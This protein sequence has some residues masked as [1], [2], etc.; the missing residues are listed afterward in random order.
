M[1]KIIP[2]C[3]TL[4]ILIGCKEEVDTS[5]RY[6]FKEESV[7][8][9][10]KKHADVYSTYT[11]ILFKV[12]VSQISATTLGQL[13][14]AR[15][16]Y[17][18][19]APTNDAIQ[20]YLDT[21][22]AS[23]IIDSPSWDG[24]RDSLTLDSIR[25]VIA[26]NSIIDGGDDMTYFTT[27][28]PILQDAEIPRANMYDRRLVVHQPNKY[29]NEDL[30]LINDAPMDERNHDIPLL[31]GCIHSMNAVICPSNNTLGHLLKS[32]VDDREEGFYV[33]SMLAMAAG[34][35]DTLTLHT[36][37]VYEDKFLRGEII[38]SIQ[39]IHVAGSVLVPAPGFCTPEHRYYGY[40]YFAE[41][42]SV[43]RELLGKDPLS[44][45]PEDIM[46]YLESQNIYPEAKR[47][48]DYKDEDNLL[49]RFV[50]YHLL[51][52]RL[53]TDKL[54][55]HYNEVGYIPGTGTLGVAMSE[56]YTTMGKRRLLKIYESHE[57]NGIFL[58]RFPN[59]N[60]GRHG[61]YHELSCDPD[62][63][64]IRIGA[65]NLTGKNN[66][67]NGMLYPIDK[68]LVYDEKTR[69]NLVRNR[70][71]WD[72]TAMMPEFI[73]NDIRMSPIM[74]VPHMNVRIPVTSEYRYLE[75]VDISDD[76]QFFYWTGLGNGWLN[77]DGDEF[78]IRGL[79]DVTFRLPPVPKR[80]TYEIR[81]AVN[82]TGKRRV[83]AQ[84]YWGKDK[85]HLA[86]QGIPLD[87]RIGPTTVNTTTLS[88]PSF[89]GWEPDTGDEDYDAEIDKQLRNKGF[90]KG[91]SIHYAGGPGSGK[92]AR[93]S[94][95]NSRRI[96]V[97]QTMDPDETYY[98]RFKT[99]I[100]DIT[101]YLYM[102]YLEY[103]AKEVYDNPETP[104]DIW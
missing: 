62:K 26:Y 100:D 5:A 95:L 104:E 41:T 13:L 84:F 42:D 75:D 90:M 51:P 11:D 43:W 56:F 34:L 33:A 79:Q 53:P 45:T 15:G 2:L 3:M 81:Y 9:Y 7:T 29:E 93:E 10:L 83:I 37:Y 8:S 48:Q 68:L 55:H 31:N 92:P 23:D 28:F 71:R 20:L 66:V 46:Q 54:V 32:Y 82:N 102:D 57:S 99:V 47:N 19:F 38:K 103:C 72:V 16:H 97:R 17:T 30:Y 70:I 60:N 74:D 50:T 78:T 6:V 14:S 59:L 52:V 87:L 35:I 4:L 58:N 21:L 98:I 49:N 89:L 85:N 96:I 1:K 44:V 18:V 94:E 63:V 65:P 22:A 39:P 67:R 40:T 91:A 24:F 64:G 27:S 73:N 77:Y 36:D 12:P 88:F 80:S 101:L 69:N 61:N 25:K 76:T 86:V